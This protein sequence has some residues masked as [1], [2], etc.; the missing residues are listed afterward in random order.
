HVLVEHGGSGE[1]AAV[2][3]TPN[4]AT[5]RFDHLTVRES[6]TTGI[7]VEGFGANVVITNCRL[8]ANDGDGIYSGLLAYTTIDRCDFVDNGD[9]GISVAYD[10]DPTP[11]T[12]CTFS[13]NQDGAILVAPWHIGIIGFGHSAADDSQAI[14]FN[15]LYPTLYDYTVSFDNVGLPYEVRSSITVDGDD[16]VATLFLK[17][18]TQ[19][20][21][22]PTAS[23]TIT[24]GTAIADIFGTPEAPVVLAGIGGQPWPGLLADP[25]DLSIAPGALVILHASGGYLP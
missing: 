8:E 2:D 13:G 1:F 20:R 19:M 7:G 21:F 4:K 17:E 15:D 3:V 24:P 11:I 9:E 5:A 14:V 22:A 10:G 6:A 12:N 23:L 16:G 25:A 18:G